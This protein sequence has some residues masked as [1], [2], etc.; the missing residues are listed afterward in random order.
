MESEQGLLRYKG[1]AVSTSGWTPPG[2]TDLRP[3]EASPGTKPFQVWTHLLF[4]L[5]VS[6]YF[7]RKENAQEFHA[8]NFVFLSLSPSKLLL[9]T[10]SFGDAVRVHL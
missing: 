5:T 8:E 1:T 10:S 3:A 6:V 2:R 4:S 7:L 9:L